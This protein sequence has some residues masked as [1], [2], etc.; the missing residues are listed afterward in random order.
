MPSPQTQIGSLSEVAMTG[1]ARTLIRYVCMTD[2]RD[3]DRQLLLKIPERVWDE[4]ESFIGS[5]LNADLQAL[6]AY[7]GME[8]IA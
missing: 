5:A 2:P 4:V 6:Y 3:I 7:A 1:Y 8:P